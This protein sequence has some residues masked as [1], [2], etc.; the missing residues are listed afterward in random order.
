[1]EKTNHRALRY[2]LGVISAVG[3]L[4]LRYLLSPL[5]GENNPY[6]T[7]WLGV[8]FSAWFCGLGPSIVTAV[9]ETL[10]VWYWFLLPPHSF[11]TPERTQIYGMLGFLLFSAM[12]IAL[13][14]S[15]RQGSASR[16]KLAAIIDS[17][18]D[19]IVSKSLEG[20]ITSW[21]SGAERIFGWT[22][23][24]VVGKPITIIVP[25]ELGH[26]EA[27]ILRHLKAGGRISHFETVRITKTGERV[28]VSL[29]IS[30][31]KDSTGRVV[32]ASKIARDITEKKA[33]E[34]KLKTAHE[35]LEERVRERTA[36]LSKKNDELVKQSST[37]RD[38]SAR[39]LTLQDQER[40]RI[41]RELHDSVGQLL[42]AMIMNSATVSLEKGKLG[43]A[44]AG[45]LEENTR[46]VEQVSQEIRTISH[47]LHPPLLD[48]VGLE[49][50][51]RDYVD[52][53]VKRSKIEVSLDVPSRIERLQNDLEISL[54]RVV[55]EC[56]TNIHR[57]SGS[58]KAAIRLALDD[59]GIRLEIRDEG[60]GIP[61]QK[62]TA[63][64]CYG[65]P[66]VGLR[67]MRERVRQLG[68]TFRIHSDGNG[69]VV[70]V[71]LPR[72]NSRSLS[73]SESASN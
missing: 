53:F 72:V 4:Y 20:V 14:E 45:C 18:E 12:I 40:R 61:P 71:T 64:D 68:G 23:E 3:A 36:E 50:A 39:L 33:T 1:M 65:A 59:D 60:R 15:N 47:L 24:E 34:A 51:I 25:P 35:G 73:A 69:T 44:A 10:G 43:M 13:G 7:A 67:G 16:F 17:S 28:D 37:V 58:L 11:V 62:Q 27:D 49:S 70:E 46:L 56:L 29:S 8:A 57:H 9:I 5:L 6:H 30:P 63:V 21:N 32:G 41:A 42:A 31:I 66:G 19:A 52:G 54:F 38:L 22:A 55:Q 48:D 26:Q 2:L